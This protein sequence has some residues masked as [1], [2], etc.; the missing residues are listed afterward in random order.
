MCVKL[1][2][3][4]SEPQCASVSEIEMPQ[5]FPGR[6]PRR[7]TLCPRGHALAAG[8]AT[9]LAFALAAALVAALSSCSPAPNA[10]PVTDPSH[11]TAPLAARVVWTGERDVYLVAKDSVSL[12][13]GARLTFLA[14]ADVIATAEV[15]SVLDAH[16]IAA[17]ISSGGLHGVRDPDR[18]KI[19]VGVPEV[20]TALALRVGVPAVALGAPAARCDSIELNAPAPGGYRADSV[21]G[22][23]SRWVRV[24]PGAAGA[25]WP[26]TLVVVAF[27]DATDEEIALERGELDLGVF[28]PGDPSGALRENPRWQPLALGVRAHGAF[29]LVELPGSAAPGA[30]A[31][32]DEAAPLLDALNR[33]VFRGDLLPCGA[34]M[35]TRSANAPAGAPSGAEA[36]GADSGANARPRFRVDRSVPRHA[37]VALH[38]G[39]AGVSPTG[40]PAQTWLL[41]YVD[42]LPAGPAAGADSSSVFSIRCPVVCASGRRAYLRALGVDAI[43]NLFECASRSVP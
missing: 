27:E 34:S 39:G 5:R 42:S 3:R 36:R 20:R 37:E 9:P 35:T 2:T 22:H 43:A 33:D 16:V 23:E 13:P 4:R 14:R 41:S 29:T 31:A 10:R 19:R 26:D 7:P 25:P 18:L 11:A 1:D 8:G 17:K 24:T 40:A 15:A 12:E 32:R 30:R 21:G 6:A 28:W 38:L